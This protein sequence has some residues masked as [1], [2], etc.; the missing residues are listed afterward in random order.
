[1]PDIRETNALTYHEK[2]DSVQHKALWTCARLMGRSEMLSII[3][4]FLKSRGEV[5]IDHQTV[6]DVFDFYYMR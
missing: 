5:G 2:L 6:E 4:D 3:Y 1:M